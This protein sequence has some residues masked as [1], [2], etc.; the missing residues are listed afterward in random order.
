MS[1]PFNINFNKQFSGAGMT[2]RGGGGR[3]VCGNGDQLWLPYTVRGDQL[4]YDRP[5]KIDY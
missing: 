2:I 1:S 4:M 3:T 5:S